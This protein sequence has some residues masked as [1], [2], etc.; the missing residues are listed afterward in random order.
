MSPATVTVLRSQA[1]RSLNEE[2]AARVEGAWERSGSVESWS[3]EVLPT[4]R[5]RKDL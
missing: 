2:I 4:T 1:R 3:Q 5:A